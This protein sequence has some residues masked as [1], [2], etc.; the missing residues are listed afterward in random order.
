MLVMLGCAAVVPLSPVVN[1][2]DGLWP[3]LVL[4]M[5]IALVHQGWVVNLSAIV[6]DRVPKHL[7]G[8]AFGV[9]AAGSTFG[10]MLMNEL[11]KRLAKADRYDLWFVVM[12]FLHPVAWLIL[13]AFRVHRE[14]KPEAAVGRG[15]EV[16]SPAKAVHA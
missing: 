5:V 2:M 13:W 6:V 12:A 10:G 9:V 15:F 14:P 11:V 3:M 4:L 16:A 1:M 8:T 7:V